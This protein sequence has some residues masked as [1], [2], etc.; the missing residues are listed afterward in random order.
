MFLQL[1]KSPLH[2]HQRITRWKQKPYTETH[3]SSFHSIKKKL[4]VFSVKS[5][6]SYTYTGK[7]GLILVLA[8]VTTLIQYIFHITHKGKMY[9]LSSVGHCHVASFI[10]HP[11]DCF[12]YGRLLPPEA[13]LTLGFVWSVDKCYSHSNC[14]GT[15]CD[16]NKYNN[17]AVHLFITFG[18]RDQG[19]WW[20]LRRHYY[21]NNIRS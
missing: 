21:I 13:T 18:H 10:F 12:S 2:V 6:S 4:N 1:I 3:L 15:Q 9:F 14:L 8:L 19:S 16:S 17:V 7:N 5:I 11:W 20:R